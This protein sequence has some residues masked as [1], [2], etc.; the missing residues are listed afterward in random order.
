M[1]AVY[2]KLVSNMRNYEVRACP[3]AG[4]IKR[5]DIVALGK[6]A[7]E[8][9]LLRGCCLGCVVPSGRKNDIAGSPTTAPVALN[10]GTATAG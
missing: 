4:A 2:P 9:A 5:G 1:L 7:V 6:R 8:V 3:Q 10:F